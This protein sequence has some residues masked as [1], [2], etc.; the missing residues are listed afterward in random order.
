[1]RVQY[2]SSDEAHAQS[3]VKAVRSYGSRAIL[4]SGGRNT[5]TLAGPRVRAMRVSTFRKAF[6]S[7]GGDAENTE[8]GTGNRSGKNRQN[9][10]R[11]KPPAERK[12]EQPPKERSDADAINELIDLVD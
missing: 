6:D 12:A 11:Q 2:S 7:I 3:V 10:R 5:E 1:V 4:I 8:R 9:R